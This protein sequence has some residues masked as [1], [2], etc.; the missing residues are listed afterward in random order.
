[1]VALALLS[2]VGIL[3]WLV[4]WIKPGNV[5]PN[6]AVLLPAF[7]VIGLV[8]VPL[9]TLKLTTRITD[10]AIYVRLSPPPL[11][12]MH[13]SRIPWTSV[14]QAYVRE[15]HEFKEYGGFGIRYATPSIGDAITLN[16]HTGLQLE[17]T[18]GKKLL[19]STRRPDE[20]EAVLAGLKGRGLTAE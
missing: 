11:Y 20:L 8:A 6:I 1:V 12:R 2:V 17:L 7:I 3:L 16:A 9:A 19:I 18:N 4:W 13:P 5:L 14:R 15:Y 10:Q